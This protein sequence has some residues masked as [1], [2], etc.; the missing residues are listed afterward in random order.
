M[1]NLR[2]MPARASTA[3]GARRARLN[4][5][6]SDG[7]RPGY[8]RIG[9]AGSET[10]GA[11][12]AGRPRAPRRKHLRGRR[13]SDFQE[14]A[15]WWDWRPLRA[16]KKAKAS[17]L[18]ASASMQGRR[19]V[20]EDRVFCDPKLN[21][22]TSFFGVFDGHGGVGAAEFVSENVGK[23]LSELLESEVVQST[24]N[25][26]GKS[27]TLLKSLYADLDTRLC[28]EKSGT[29]ALTCL[30]SHSPES[31]AVD[32]FVIANAGDSVACL[33]H[34][35]HCSDV[36]DG[37]ARVTVAKVTNIHAPNVPEEKRR[38]ESAGFQVH[39]VFYGMDTPAVPRIR[40]G[41]LSVSRA[42]GDWEYKQ[43]AGLSRNEQA[44]V[45]SPDVHAFKACHESGEKHE[46]WIL[47]LSDGVWDAFENPIEI[48]SFL[49]TARDRC[50]SDCI[51]AVNH[52]EQHSKLS[53]D[54][55][56]ETLRSSDISKYQVGEPFVVYP[57]KFS[58]LTFVSDLIADSG[59]S[60]PGKIVLRYTPPIFWDNSDIS[61]DADLKATLCNTW[62]AGMVADALIREAMLR[63]GNDNLSAVLLQIPDAAVEIDT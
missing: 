24:A 22:L 54:Y 20:Q 49:E 8:R 25:N 14:S 13:L 6:C 33:I 30:L 16:G 19:S 51:A 1:M 52:E 23:R 40:P 63:G 50:L 42:L 32:H 57:A 34:F 21:A 35:N 12:G 10:R 39:N 48:A 15:V 60:G 9:V 36:E 29:C 27:S 26:P 45:A 41:G 7:R 5:L 53:A 17:F 31:G 59:S 46:S 47:L 61:V 37:T 43:K 3:A 11:R 38:I 55:A 28:T 2:T 4:S 56:M 58:S 62:A 44:I 18:A